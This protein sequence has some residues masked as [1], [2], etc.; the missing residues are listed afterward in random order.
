MLPSVPGLRLVHG[1]VTAHQRL[2]SW[3]RTL[4]GIGTDKLTLRKKTLHP[5]YPREVGECR[6]KDDPNVPRGGELV[7]AWEVLSQASS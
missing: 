7:S 5:K 3:Q 6:R 2:L 1:F 4:G